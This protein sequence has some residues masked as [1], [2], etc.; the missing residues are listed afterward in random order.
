MAEE[1]V[2]DLELLKKISADKGVEIPEEML[3]LVAGGKTYTYHEWFDIL[4]AQERD[5]ERFNSEIELATLGDCS[6]EIVP[7]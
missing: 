3:D 1:K 7:D 2:V 5:T 6:L 4:T